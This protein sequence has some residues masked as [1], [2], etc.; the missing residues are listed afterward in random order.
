MPLITASQLRMHYGGPLLLDDVSVSIEAGQR[1]GIIGP[2]GCGKS[3]LL[4]LLQGTLSPTEGHVTL[5]RDTRVAMQVQELE[6]RADQTAFAYVETAFAAQQDLE[7]R[8][9]A[10][11]AAIEESAAGSEE[12]QR[13]LARYAGLQDQQR[14]G[15]F[16]DVEHR[17]ARMLSSLGLPE[18][19][20]HRPLAGFSGGE[21]NII[22]LARCLLMDPDVLLLDEPSNHL[23][24]DGIEWFIRFVRKSRAAIV[25]VSHNR[26]VLDATAH[27]IWELS[28]ARVTQ[29]TGNY[30]DYQRQK[31]EH[32]ARL[33]RQFKVQQRLIQ[34][35]EF[36]ARRLRDMAAAYDDPGQAKRAK[37][38]L[39]RVEQMDRVER[40]SSQNRSFKARLDSGGRHGRIALTIKDFDF[41]YGERVLFEQA[42]VEIE[43]GERVCLVGT[44]GS[45]KTTLVR[46][47]LE[48][49]DWENP[50]L[51]IGRSVKLAEYRQFHDELAEGAT[52][53]DWATH[54]LTPDI[55]TASS[56]LHRFLFTREDLDRSVTTLS[57]GEKSRLQLAR[58]VH[59]QV[60]FLILDEPTNHLDIQ[61][62]EQL[63][64]MLL[65]FDGTLL[66]ISHDRYFLDRLVTRVVEVCDRGLQSYPVDFATWWREREDDAGRRTALLDRT[67]VRDKDAARL[68]HEARKE[69]RREEQRVRSRHARIEGEI[70]ELETQIESLESELEQAYGPEA[71]P[72]HA[73]QLLE[74]LE[75]SR[76]RLEAAY[77]EWEDAAAAV[78]ALDADSTD[79]G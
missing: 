78:E 19:V 29:W 12:Q 2:N 25:M 72:A 58:L 34:R 21:R 7:Q 6:A 33:E 60:N 16:T 47:I 22:A 40:P 3:T 20:W 38:M 73:P 10:F 71:D 41:A 51:R 62:C 30:S 65:E 15:G 1:I 13:L 17:V 63:E 5:Q 45:G 50:T 11:E 26:H 64:E 57:G 66:I 8:L 48:H 27:E 9:R 14:Q 75:S 24:M 32:E 53:L 79:G 18:S 44:N 43:Y 36:Q 4:K 35:L 42:N 54:T 68:A 76:S 59:E 37:A 52:L 77:A 46:Q 55:P 61:A 28:R 49:G 56:L 23:D 74:R 31:A 69:R 67:E 70:A 39:K